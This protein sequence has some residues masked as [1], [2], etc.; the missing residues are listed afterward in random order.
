MK[1]YVDLINSLEQGNIAPVYLFYGEENYLREKALEKF[2]EKLLPPPTADFNLDVLDGEEV[3]EQE[4]VLRAQTP[5]LGTGWRMVIVRHALFFAASDKKGGSAGTSSRKISQS[6]ERE[7]PLLDYLKQPSPTT[8]LIF[9]TGHPVDQRRRLFKAIKQTGRVVEF[10]YLKPR[11]LVRWLDRQA[12]LAGKTIAPP[13]A[14]LLVRRVGPSLSV[15]SHEIEKAIAYI[16]Q[17]KFILDE[18]IYR[19]TVPLVEENIFNVVDAIGERRVGQALTG[20][21]ELLLKGQPGPVILAMVARQFRLILQAFELTERRSPP[22]EL[23]G[24]L[25]VPPFVARKVVAQTANFSRE[26]V[27]MVL[28]KLLDLD[29]A[30]K[31]GRQEFY[32]GMEMLMLEL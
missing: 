24:Q 1:Y 10:P 14:E 29:R 5:P 18:D 2:R 8:C 23:A 19:L 31:S 20:I 17:R 3:A 32:P 28:K 7:S 11:D 27:I 13:V 22:G 21:R 16:G 15:L 6:R 9:N 30:V 4:I 25:G 26:Q 12:R